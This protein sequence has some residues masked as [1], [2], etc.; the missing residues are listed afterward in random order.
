VLIDWMGEDSPDNLAVAARQL[1][2]I[3][4]SAAAAE[5]A[6]DKLLRNRSDKV[7]A[8]AAEAVTKVNPHRKAECVDEPSVRQRARDALERIESRSK[9]AS[10]RSSEN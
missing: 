6:L 1:G 8:T 5:P 3:G 10:L 9:S 7:R 2:E 4:L